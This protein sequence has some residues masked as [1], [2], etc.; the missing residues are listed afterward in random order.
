MT[1][2]THDE[3]FEMLDALAFEALEEAERVSVVAHVAECDECRVELVQL[4]ETVAAIAL[5]AHTARQPSEEARDKV[6]SRLMARA[7]ADAEVSRIEDARAISVVETTRVITPSRSVVNAIA[8]RR[9]EWMAIAAGILLVVSVSI[10]ASVLRDRDNLRDALTEQVALGHKATSATDS[11]RALAMTK[12]SIIAGL[13]GRDVAMM[14]L[15]SAGTKSPYAHMFWD[16]PHSTWTMVA[17]NMPQLKAGRTYQLWLVTPDK[18]ISAGTFEARDGDAMVR[19][20]MPLN[21][22]LMALAVTEEP[23]GGMPQP[24]GSMVMIANAH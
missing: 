22:K 2:L 8:W 24:T 12:D 10:L 23:M 9:A 20:T 1:R 13:T 5:V 7:S 18:K 6:K 16:K 17:H 3:A 21:D 15:T 11:L 19:A 4:R 14:T